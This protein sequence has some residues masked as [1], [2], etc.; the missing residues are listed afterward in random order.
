MRRPRVY[1]CDF[2]TAI[3]HP[4]KWHYRPSNDFPIPFETFAEAIAAAVLDTHL[5]LEATA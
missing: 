3:D 5:V 4:K 2:C 1:K